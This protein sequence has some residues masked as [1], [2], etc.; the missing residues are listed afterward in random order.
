MPGCLNRNAQ[1]LTV[2]KSHSFDHIGG[3]F[4]H[5]DNGW[6]LFDTKVPGPAGLIV[7]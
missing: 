1:S 4:G 3:A 7:S 6:P 2:S 5:H